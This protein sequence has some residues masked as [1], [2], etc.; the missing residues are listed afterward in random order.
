M[1]AVKGQDVIIHAAAQTGNSR[2]ERVDQ[3]RINVI[4]TR[5]IARACNRARAKL[6]HIS[7]VAA[8]G[9]S[10]HPEQPANEDFEFNLDDSG[11][12]YHISKHG[13]EEAVMKEAFDGLK[14]VIVNPALIWGPEH[15]SYRGART[16]TK[17][18]KSWILPYGPGGQ[19]IVHVA[20]VVKGILLA[21]KR[22][23]RGERYILGGDNVSFQKMNETTCRE[24]GILRL[25]VPIPGAIAESGNRVKNGMHRLLR[26]QRLPVYDKRF[27][28][29]FYD[30]SKARNELGFSA[31][32]FQAIVKEW[33]RYS[34]GSE[35]PAD[36]LRVCSDLNRP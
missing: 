13:A 12:E 5:N 18:V 29:Q 16:L 26:K 8:I 10:P 22:G 15:E 28:H 2:S 14:A 4:G 1:A 11:M 30:S 17:S 27:C 6:I 23:R 25:Q 7:S 35:V 3:Y 9:I 20:D 24:L 33:I 21:L 36:Q 32:S 31:R 34:E 19:C